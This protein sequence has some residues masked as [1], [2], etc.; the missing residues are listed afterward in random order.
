MVMYF[1][2]PFSS[3]TTASRHPT[4]TVLTLTPLATDT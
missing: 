3:L 4:A 1:I 2:S